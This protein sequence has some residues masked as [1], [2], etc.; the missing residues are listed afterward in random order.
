[1]TEFW[2]AHASEVWSAILGYLAGGLT[3]TF[4]K[5]QISR[6]QSS[7][8]GRIVDQSGANAGGDIVGGNKDSRINKK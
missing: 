7:G 1:M 6:K 2:A 8:G 5:F 3:V 4:V